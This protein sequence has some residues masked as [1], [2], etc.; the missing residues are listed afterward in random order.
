MGTA[1]F[2]G[3]RVTDKNTPLPTPVEHPGAAQGLE[4]VAAIQQ[5]D[6]Y[7]VDHWA[8]DPFESGGLNF[9]YRGGLVYSGTVYSQVA[10]GS[11]TLPV[12]A[13]S[14]VE[15][16]AAGLVT[17]NTSGF[18]ATKVPMAKVHT[19]SQEITQVED[20]RPETIA[21]ASGPVGPHPLSSHT[22][23]DP[24]TVPTTAGHFLRA[25]GTK[26]VNSPISWADVVKAGSS[27]ADLAARAFTD[28]TFSGLT[29]GRFLKAITATTVAF[30][31]LTFADISGVLGPTAGGTG[32]SAYTLGDTLY[33]SAANVLSVLPG[34]ITATRKFLRQTGSGAVSA[35]PTWD[36]I[37]AADVPGSAFSKADDTNVTATLSGSPTTAVLNAMTFTLGWTGTLAAGR[38][39]ANVVQSVV[40]DTNFTGSIAAQVLTLGFTGSIADSRLATISTAGKVA[41]SATTATSANTASTIVL[42]DGSGNFAAGTITAALTGNADTATKWATARNLAGNSVD[43]SANVAFANKFVVQGTADAGLS[44]AQFLGALATGIVKNTVTT[45][46]LS[47]AV[48]GDFPTLNQ[49]T[50][51]TAAAWTTGR[52]LSITGDLAYTSPSF[53]GSGNVTAAGTLASVATAGTTGSSTAIP[54]ITINA[55][56]LTTSITTAAVIAPAG[57][58][59]GTT[60]NATVVTSSLTSLGTLAAALLFTDNTYDIGASGATRPRAGYFGTTVSV[61]TDFTHGLTTVLKVGGNTAGIAIYN[62]IAPSGDR[63]WRVYASSSSHLEFDMTNDGASTAASWMQVTRSGN[64]A[65]TVAINANLTTE[66]NSSHTLTTGAFTGTTGNFTDTTDASSSAAAALK[67]AGG[68]AV[69]KGMYLGTGPLFI[70]AATDNRE[71]I[72]YYKD[73]TFEMGIQKVAGRGADWFIAGATNFNFVKRTYGTV[74]GT[75]IM[76]VSDTGQLWVSNIAAATVGVGLLA[77]KLPIYDTSGTLK[78]YI[79]IYATIT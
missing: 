14:Y 56:G 12:S 57:T 29:A 19:N 31:A 71:A 41:N 61:G 65:T 63:Q 11:F 40:N 44:A 38:L 21:G 22:D 1:A 32:L 8:Y 58:L 51:G 73:G 79:P 33:A 70:G 7:A 30:A 66:A 26:W 74:G 68:L 69:A 23:V 42:R 60:L 46:V 16:D 39:N 9:H 2:G 28:L 36:T 17:H 54:V 43:G 18:T 37:L 78:G 5:L 6:A 13:I 47:I 75:V 34:Q 55:K 50:T 67:T 27:L 72:N 24:A 45:G 20:W 10:A 59:T 77:D 64:T 53:D 3:I 35:A 76:S 49:N 48:A 15:R 4:M 25:N 52:T 62:T